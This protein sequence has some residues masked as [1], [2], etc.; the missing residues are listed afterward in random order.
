MQS[1][2]SRHLEYSNTI[3]QCQ[4]LLYPAGLACLYHSG[5]ELKQL[6]AE[7]IRQART[8]AGLSGTELGTKLA[9]LLG[10]ERGNTKAN[11]SHWENQRNEPSIQQLIAISTIT[12]KPLPPEVVNH[13]PVAHQLSLAASQQQIADDNANPDDMIELLA[14]FQ[15]TDAKGRRY[16]MSAAR[17]ATKVGNVRWRK[18]VGDE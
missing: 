5:M 13:A 17:S 9:L 16:I 4:E 18:V 15:Q 1:I 12:G 10:V 6:I 8:D 14:L 11:I 3:P 7:W 2:D